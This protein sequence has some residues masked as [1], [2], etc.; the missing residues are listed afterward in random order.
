MKRA[1][2]RP[3][4]LN[5][6]LSIRNKILIMSLALLLVPTLTVSFMS[7]GTA[8]SSLDAGGEKRLRN[9]VEM[10]LSLISLLDA[11]VQNGAIEKEAAQEFVRI[12]ML[13]SK[14]EDG[15]RP[16]NK[17]IDLGANG[18]P[19]AVTDDGITVAH[20]FNEGVS[21]SGMSDSRGNLVRDSKLG[22]PAIDAMKIRAD[23]GG[24]YV[25]YDYMLPGTED[26][27]AKITYVER[28]P[29]WGWIVAAGTYAQDFNQGAQEIIRIT[30]ITVAVMLAVGITAIVWFARSLTRPIVQVAGFAS[31]VSKGNLLVDPVVCKSKD[32]TSQLASSFNEMVVQLRGLVNEVGRSVDQVAATSEELMASGEQTSRASEHIAQTIQ[33]VAEGAEKQ[34]ASADQ[35]YGVIHDMSA[36]VQQIAS[37]TSQVAYAAQ[38]TSTQ[39]TEGGKTL[40]SAIG[41]METVESSMSSLSSAVAGLGERTKEIVQMVDIISDIAAQTNL[42]ALNASIEAARAGEHGRGF[43]VVAGEVR[44]L[45]EQTNETSSQIASIVQMIGDETEHVVKTMKEAESVVSGG[46]AAVGDAGS[47]FRSIREDVEGVAKGIDEVS[48]AA[49][50]IAAGTEQ[51][52]GAM[53]QVVEISAEGASGTQSVSAAAQEQSASM[54]EIA[55]ASSMLARMAEALQGQI[56][57][58]KV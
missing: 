18:Y 23:E 53:K 47:M 8:V 58:F 25:Y 15:T 42:L 6:K 26:Y 52:M 41:Q 30:V 39:A 54:E 10:T 51:V 28:D 45:A 32:E 5:I 7:Y 56:S 14:G 9:N 29:H 44:K 27:A 31:E 19:F 22:V 50:G 40:Q 4:K 17:E 24:G 35:S 20:P 1:N 12:S 37:S 55:A 36:S 46:I 34:A 57:K 13:G 38:R 49:A 16:I 2:K 11:Q 3:V 33:Q 43:A 48:Q 21:M